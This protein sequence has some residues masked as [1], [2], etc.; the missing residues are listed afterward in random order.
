MGRMEALVPVVDDKG[1]EKVILRT[2]DGKEYKI[3][4][5]TSKLFTA[6]SFRYH[7]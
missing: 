7:G 5:L 2:K 1:L 6:N 3:P 4:V